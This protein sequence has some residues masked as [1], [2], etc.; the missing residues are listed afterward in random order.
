MAEYSFE[1][2]PNVDITKLPLSNEEGMAVARMLGRRVT[3]AELVREGLL[4][5][6]KAEAV[7]DALVKKGALVRVG[8]VQQK[9]SSS[10]A[11]SAH[12][13]VSGSG[14][15]VKGPY[16]DIMFSAAD[17]AEACE[18]TEDQKKR[19]L[20]VEMHITKWSHYKLLGIKRTAQGAEIKAGYFKAS[21]EFHPDAYFRK[22]L[23][24][25]KDRIDRIF[26]AMKGAYELLSDNSRRDEYDK[27]AVIELGPEEEAELEKR[28]EQKRQEAEA[29]ERDARNAER[30]RESRLKRNPMMERINKGRDMM[31]MAEDA[32]RAGKVEE[33]ANHARLAATYDESLKARVGQFTLEADKLRASNMMKRV[34]QVLASPADAHALASEI[35]RVADEASEIAIATKDGP[36]LVDTSRALLALKRPSRAAKLAAMATDVEPRNPRAWEA[37]AEA[38]N[39]D[40]KWATLLKASERWLALDPK[41]ARAKELHREGKRQT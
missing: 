34:F 29:K 38:A 26:R 5:P 19:I 22:S 4:P 1:V 16:D 24:S 11:T 17:L 35:N 7:V 14:R 2:A 10:G 39:A 41:S 13:P 37:L 28:L 12:G 40:N 27:T 33:A 15:A 9:P 30:M 3:L 21:K 8:S 23:G 25:Y 18:L 32:H 20:F 36:L 6:G 31:K